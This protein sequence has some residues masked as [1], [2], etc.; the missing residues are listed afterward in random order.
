MGII[1]GLVPGITYLATR[2]MDLTLWTIGAEA[3]F[4]GI[5]LGVSFKKLHDL[6]QRRKI[7]ENND[8]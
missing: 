1:E 2:R 4:T 5:H 8:V 6:E 7:L 3:V